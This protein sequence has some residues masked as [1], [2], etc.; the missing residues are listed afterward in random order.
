M[1]SSSFINRIRI[2]DNINGEAADDF[3]G[4]SVSLSADGSVVAIGAFGNDGNGQRSGHVRIFFN[5][6]GSWTQIGEDINGEASGDRSGEGESVRLSADGS[7]VAIGASF[8]GDN[9]NSNGHVRLYK[10]DNVNNT[11]TQIGEDINGEATLDYSGRHIS[12]SADGSVVAIGAF[13]NDGNG[14]RSGH[15]RIYKNIDNAWTQVGTDID[16][17][18]AFDTSG[19]SVSLSAD[20]SIVAIGASGNDGNGDSSGHVRIY[21]NINNTWTQVGTDIDGEGFDDLSGASVS[22]S[23]DGSVVA[24]SA[25]GRD[26]RGYLRIY[27]NINNTWTQIGEDIDGEA[28]G[29][30]SGNSISLSADGSIIAI[31]AYSNDDNGNDSG[32]VRLYKNV[33]NTWIKIGSDIDGEGIG[34][35]SGE[36]VSL[37]ADGSVVAIGATGND[38]NGNDS[39]HVRVFQTG[40]STP[41][42]INNSSGYYSGDSS[43]FSITENSTAIHAF[44]SNKNVTWSLSGGADQDLFNIDS[45][46]GA[47][48]FR[49]APDFEN[50]TD[51]DNNNSY[52]VTVRATDLA[53][54]TSDQTVTTNVLYNWAQIGDNI[55]GEAAD[56]FSGSSVSLSA[57]GSVV[58]IG[59]FG[60][61]GNGQRSGHVRIFFNDNGSWTQIGEDINGEASGDRSGEGE[62]VRLSADGSVVAIGA[63]F[64]GDNGNSN[65]HVRLYK[66]DN[67]N[68]TWTQIGEDINGEAT[69]DYSGRHISLSA[70]GSVVAIGAFGNDGNGERSGHVRIYKNIDNAWTQVGTDI[71]GEAAFDTSGSSVSLSADGS[72]VAIGAS[73]NDGNGDSS[74]HVRIYKNINNTWTQVGTDIDGE[75]FDD[76]SGASVSLSADG[77]V[78]AISALGRDARGYLRIYKNINN[79]W[80]QIGEDIDGEASGDRSGN[81]ISLSADGS[82]I[83]IGAYSNDDNGNDSGHVRLYKNVNNTWIKIGSDIDGEG[84][85]DMSGY[86]VRLS[87][88]GSFV[89]IG[90]T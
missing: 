67:V 84:I 55:N 75:G 39:G 66:N 26:A 40:I 45:D 42:L 43:T 44:T 18:A 17:E 82:I 76:L 6:N 16:G 36:S 11:W 23:A 14:E 74:G 68:N 86:S 41:P 88:D 19:S 21:K 77:S 22:L 15:V 24:I 85:G 62:S 47:L 34:D 61:D 59:A 52:I 87:A 7:V 49:A 65:G 20:G 1:M 13:G 58:A 33:N 54:N 37:S 57:D 3:S 64:N 71:D 35:K 53:D 81:S 83:A 63:S 79:T 51:S 4:S 8:N 80:T 28:S 56:D 12:L 70:D 50:P 90:A 48:T 38:D 78:V 31:G 29:D 73:G 27:K 5:D 32:H 10:N 2:G 46:T 9:G 89:A 30:R 69:L 25:L 60:N 72:I